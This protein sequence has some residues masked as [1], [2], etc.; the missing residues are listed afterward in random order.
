MPTSHQI[1]LN[2]KEYVEEPFLRQLERLGWKI[3]WAGDE[4][5]GDPAVTFREGFNEVILEK[6]LRAFLLKINSWLHED[7]L[8]PIIRELTTPGVTGGLIENNRYILEK[9]LEGTSAED[10]N[11]HK[12]RPVHFIDF[13]NPE[14]NDFLAISQFK[15]NIPGTENHIIPDIILFLNGLPVGVV[16]CKSAY[17]HDP[18]GEAVEQLMQIGRASCR[19]RVQISVVLVS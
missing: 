2:E 15:V 16:E 13:A 9:L 14:A 8:S 3:L 12:P 7:Q 17:L 5:K 19:E 10:R 1:A 4:G 18:I 6:K 11:T